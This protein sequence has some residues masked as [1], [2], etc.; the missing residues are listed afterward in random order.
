MKKI[1]SI[2]ALLL[3]SF[4][5][6]AQE[7]INLPSQLKSLTEKGDY[8][9]LEL[10]LNK[11]DEFRTMDGSNSSLARVAVYT[12]N[13]QGTEVISKGFEGMNSIVTILKDLKK[14][15]WRLVEVYPIKGE[16]LILTHYILERKK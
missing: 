10:R 16:S 11:E 4:G 5:V 1:L 8:I 7:K 12:G 9:I 13:N 6:D 2:L 3:L 14:N 15:G